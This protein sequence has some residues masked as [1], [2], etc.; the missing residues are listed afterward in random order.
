MTITLHVHCG[1]ASYGGAGWDQWD[2]D[3]YKFVQALKGNAPNRY[4]TLKRP[5]GTWVKITAQDFEPAFVVF[6]EWAA[7]KLA[8]LGLANGL[9]VPVPASSCVAVGTDAK[10]RK[11]AQAIADRSAG[12]TVREAICWDEVLPKASEGGSRDPD[13]LYPHLR[14]DTE[15]PNQPIILVDDVSTTA[16]RL[17]ACTRGL[18]HFGYAVEHAIC[19]A[20]TVHARPTAGMFSGWSR[21]IAT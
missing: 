9:L 19:A 12:F 11:I 3:A 21:Q 16:S 18:R 1:Y 14:Y 8:S 15:T 20:E 13:S 17:I 5:D 6:G 7:A 2:Y 4:A 10:G